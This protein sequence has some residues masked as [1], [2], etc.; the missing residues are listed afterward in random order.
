M[1]TITRDR[2]LAG[3]AVFSKYADTYDAMI[4]VL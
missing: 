4:E 1:R 2:P 3:S